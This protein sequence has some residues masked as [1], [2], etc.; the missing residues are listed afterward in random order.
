VDGVARLHPG[1]SY[2]VDDRGVTFLPAP[3]LPSR[4]DLDPDD[5]D[6]WIDAYLSALR[7]ALTP[8]VDA[9][10]ELGCSLSG[11]LD[12]RTLLALLCSMGAAPI[13]VTFGDPDHPDRVAAARVAGAAGVRHLCSDLPRGGP[14]EHLDEIADGTGG[15]G[16]LALLAGV[17][18]HREVAGRVGR[19]VSG[20][21]GDALFGPLPPDPDGLAAALPALR[22]DRRRLL[23]PD[24]A[25]VTDR[26]AEARA[27]PLAGV[28]GDGAR[29]APLL[30]WRQAR[31]IADGLRLR[32]RHTPV[33]AAFLDPAVQALALAL[34]APLREGRRLQRE[35]L[36]RL[37]PD[38]AAL[39][40]VPAHDPPPPAHRA[41]RY[42]RGRADHLARNLWLRGTPDRGAQFDVQTALRI[43]SRWRAAMDH[44]CAHPPLG[45]DP[46]GLRRLWRRHRRGRDNLGLLFG[47]LL[48]LGRFVERWL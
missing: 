24:A 5:A 1:E 9:G 26:L 34:P 39:P 28:R 25:P 47:R 42:L 31:V 27:I 20:A 45:V 48:V 32:Q 40:L 37:A 4:S 35:A 3:P 46:D 44:L 13:A 15:T 30:R 6:G 38:L 16:N 23:L 21:S 41:A 8:A 12:S 2:V 7:R 17:S 29:L 22:D 10:G 43:H 18:A 36:A 11:G 14:L 19:L 33:T